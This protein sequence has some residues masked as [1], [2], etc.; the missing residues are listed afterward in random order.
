MNWKPLSESITLIDGII[1]QSSDKAIVE[2]STSLLVKSSTSHRTIIA[3]SIKSQLNQQSDVAQALYTGY[4]D[5]LTGIRQQPGFEDSVEQ[6]C[7]KDFEYILSIL[8]Q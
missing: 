3:T 5:A 8:Q 4:N 7:E 6:M 1:V 2:P